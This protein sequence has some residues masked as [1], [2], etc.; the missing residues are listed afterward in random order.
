VTSVTSSSSV[1][2]IERVFVMHRGRML[3]RFGLRRGVGRGSSSSSDAPGVAGIS[4]LLSSVEEDA[5]RAGERGG[6]LSMSKASS[7]EKLNAERVTRESRSF[8]EHSGIMWRPDE[9]FL[10]RVRVRV[11][12]FNDARVK[13]VWRLA[14]TIESVICDSLV[15]MLY[16]ECG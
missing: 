14:W 15:F 12:R 7:M 13:T 11:L 3:M 2:T 5:E 6:S 16:V 9:F 4:E 1:Q 10:V 8:S